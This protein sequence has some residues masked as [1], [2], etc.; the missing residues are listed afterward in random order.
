MQSWIRDGALWNHVET[1]L[2]ERSWPTMC[3]HPLCGVQTADAQVLRYHF[4]DAHSLS[5]SSSGREKGLA[6]PTPESALVKAPDVLSS[7]TNDHSPSDLKRKAADG[8]G[9]DWMPLEHLG[10][11]HFV[12]SP[13]KRRR[14][15]DRTIE[16]SLLSSVDRKNT[17][18]DRTRSSS[19]EA[20]SDSDSLFSA[21]SGTRT[22][23]TTISFSGEHDG[24][25]LGT[26]AEQ[27]D[28]RPVSTDERLFS[29]TIRSSSQDMEKGVVSSFTLDDD[30]F[31]D[32]FIRSLSPDEHSRGCVETAPRLG[33]E[34]ERPQRADVENPISKP[35]LTCRT[36]KAAGLDTATAQN[37]SV[38]RIRLLVKP[39]KPRL[40]LHFNPAHRGR[41]RKRVESYGKNSR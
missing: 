26:P 37:P 4:I 3:P 27:D 35:D 30:H 14:N 2:G 22:S 31:F 24:A 18:V 8:D 10:S 34:I 19:N 16:P 15:L 28:S 36:Q 6:I 20:E 33:D 21:C 9:L 32:Q 29:P 39:P 25:T 7:S 12:P 40:T 13:S 38:L 17:G 41:N 23:C 11:D 1:H 5:R